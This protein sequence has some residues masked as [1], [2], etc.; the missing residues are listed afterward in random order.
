M[1]LGW[2]NGDTSGN[3]MYNTQQ[4]IDEKEINPVF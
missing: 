1:H 3:P 4:H 2:K